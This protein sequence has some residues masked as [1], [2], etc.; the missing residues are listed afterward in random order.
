M[1]SADGALTGAKNALD[2]AESN[3][4]S[5]LNSVIGTN[6]KDTGWGWMPTLPNGGCTPFN[7]A[8]HEINACAVT[9][10]IRVLMSWIWSVATA[11]ACLAMVKNTIQG[12]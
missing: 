11:Y 6:G 12:A 4:E 9:E 2:G 3:R 1:P 5:T 7:I 8:G 10:R